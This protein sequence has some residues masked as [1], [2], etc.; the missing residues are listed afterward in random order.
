ML[1]QINKIDILLIFYNMSFWFL[2][3]FTNKRLRK[4]KFRKCKTRKSLKGGKLN[5]NPRIDKLTNQKIPNSCFTSDIVVKVKNA[6]NKQHP[7]EKIINSNPDEILKELKEKTSCESKEEDCIVENISGLS[8][9]EKEKIK[10]ISFRPK[11]PSEW[12]ENPNEWL[13]NVDIDKVLHQYETSDLQF[14]L[15]GPSPIDV[16][17]SSSKNVVCKAICKFN[18]NNFIQYKKIAMIFNLST[19]NEPGS[20]WVALY[21]SVLDNI[22]FYFDSTGSKPPLEI[23]KLVKDIQQKAKK[24]NIVL[25]YLDSV[26]EHQKGHSECG[27][28]VLYFIIEMISNAGNKSVMEKKIRQFQGAERITDEFIETYRLKYFN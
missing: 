11:Q 26:F 10:E 25:K 23:Q 3:Y 16:C 6:H 17:A 7:N 24:T 19:H 5:C 9:T 1:F 22:I 4:T 14:K 27:V 21:V 18:S 13:S 12:K 2:K 20:H 15:L 8:N 28:Y